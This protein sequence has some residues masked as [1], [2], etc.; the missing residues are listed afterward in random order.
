MKVILTHN[1]SYII[2]VFSATNVELVTKTRTEHMTDMDKK[3]M[4]KS[5][6]RNPIE[7][8]LGMA[9]KEEVKAQGSLNGVRAYF[10]FVHLVNI[11]HNN[12]FFLMHAF[13]LRSI[14]VY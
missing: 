10:G 8:F 3:Q 13:N 9:K 12:F 14:H 1:L 4:K 6:G 5:N 11:L 7:S 2:Q